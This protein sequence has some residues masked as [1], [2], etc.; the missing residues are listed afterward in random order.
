VREAGSGG[1]ERVDPGGVRA[2]H[3][4]EFGL[5]IRQVRGEQCSETMRLGA[6]VGVRGVAMQLGVPR[7]D[8]ERLVPS[9]QAEAEARSGATESGYSP[10]GW[11]PPST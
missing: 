3:R 5:G 1:R 8:V 9:A 6:H 4:L 10:R 11:R 2:V 7:G